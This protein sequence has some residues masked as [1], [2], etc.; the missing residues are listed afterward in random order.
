LDDISK[1]TKAWSNDTKKQTQGAVDSF[2]GVSSAL[3]RLAKQVLAIATIQKIGSAFVNAAKDASRLVDEAEKVGATAGELATLELAAR[4]NGIAV[5]TVKTAYRELQKSVN[6]ALN[7]T[8]ATGNAILQLGL[9]YTELS[10]QTPTERFYEIVDALKLVED[11]N[12]RAEIGTILL[13]KA[14]T[15]AT[16]LILKGSAGIRAAGAGALGTIDLQTIDKV[17]KAFEGV[18]EV[19]DKKIKEA[20]VALAPFLIKT[21]DGLKYIA[22][23]LTA[24]AAIV[25][26]AFLPGLLIRFGAA[27]EFIAQVI[28]FNLV[29]SLLQAQVAAAGT[30]AGLLAMT[31]VQIFGF[32]AN[33][34]GALLAVS[35]GIKAVSTALATL[36]K[37]VTVFV[38]AFE[39]VTRIV[40]AGA[41]AAGFDQYAEALKQLRESV[42][43]TVLG[44]FGFETA[45]DKIKKFEEETAQKLEAARKRAEALTEADKKMKDQMAKDAELLAFRKNLESLTKLPLPQRYNELITLFNKFNGTLDTKRQEE[46]NKAME[47]MDVELQNLTQSTL[48]SIDAGAKRLKQAEEINVLV[49]A[50]YITEQ[51]ARYATTNLARQEAAQ[52]DE[53]I[54]LRQQALQITSNSL[55]VDKEKEFRLKTL[56][57]S[58][59]DLIDPISK[60]QR[61]LTKL[62]ALEAI[63]AITPEQRKALEDYYKLQLKS[64]QIGLTGDDRLEAEQ[65][66][67]ETL[68]KINTLLP[69]QSQELEIILLRTKAL[70]NAEIQRFVS[71]TPYFKELVDFGKNFADGLANAIVEGQSFGEALRN[72]FQNIMKDI[73]VLILR[74]TI[75]QGIMAAIGLVSPTAGAAFGELTG[76]T[77]GALTPRAMGGPVNAGQPYLVGERGMELFVPQ[78]NGYVIPN[79][80][81]PS[82]TIVVNQTINVE[83]GVSQTVRAEMATLLPRFKQ[84]AMTGVLEAKQRGGSYA[85]GLSAA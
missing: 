12:K 20:L 42:E 9:S 46:L 59:V 28:S 73:A 57:Q 63:K 21:A 36:I 71:V 68:Q 27:V 75:L 70:Q 38:L 6:E 47:N 34:N 1:K 14:F 53:I 54:A 84:E 77:K 29:K 37:G 61:E 49:R 69:E 25:G 58:Y 60:L 8:E 4:K 62:N 31:R 44:F 72:T 78:S 17:T 56:G 11:Q 2:N 80:M 65:K 35:N 55:L 23:N 39:A 66:Y 45:A 81:T 48:E 74:M 16:P 33:L 30:T 43:D 64:A 82:E 76:I 50:G 67:L 22:E 79:D 41:K 5:E 40:E 15:E 10:K 3:D 32:L 18:A 52:Y 7:G 13:G 83:T 19:L 85:R 26:T 51:Q 24:F